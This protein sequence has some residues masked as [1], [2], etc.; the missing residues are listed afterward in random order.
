LRSNRNVFVFK[1]EKHTTRGGKFFLFGGTFFKNNHLKNIVFVLFFCYPVFRQKTRPSQTV[2]FTRI[3]HTTETATKFQRL[4]SNHKLCTSDFATVQKISDI[5]HF[6]TFQ[7]HKKQVRKKSVATFL[8]QSLTVDHGRLRFGHAAR[9]FSTTSWVLSSSK[10]RE[11]FF[12]FCSSESCGM[13]R[14]DE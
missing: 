14:N 10:W 8:Q 2:T 9:I 3:R 1:H 7:K 4:S 11:A 12:A 6:W 5:A 13:T